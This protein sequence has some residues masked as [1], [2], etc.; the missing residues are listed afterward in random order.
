MAEISGDTANVCVVMSTRNRY[1]MLPD[2]LRSVL[3]SEYDSFEVLVVDQSTD[4]PSSEVL[5]VLS[6]P[7]VRHMPTDT[8]GLSVARNIGF[9]AARSPIVLM[10]DDDCIVSASWI[11]DVAGAIEADP[12]VACVYTDVIPGPHDSTAGFVPYTTRPHDL[13]FDRLRDYDPAIGIG[14]SVGYRRDAL[15][16]VGGFDEQLGPGARFRAADDVDMAMRLL[17]AQF[18]VR[19][20]TTTNVV[21]LGFRTNEEG[22]QLVRGYMYG[23]AAAFAKLVRTR[24]VE[25]LRPLGRMIWYSLAR[26]VIDSIKRRELPPVLGRIEYTLRGFG[27]GLRAPIDASTKRF[28]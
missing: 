28:V 12:T 4:S 23:T 5:R 6:D 8:V 19:Y 24:E 20:I 25:A 18:P 21:H 15:I 16:A 9:R 7:R 11:A 13:R 14:A 22:R 2:A 3:E 10:T 27:A 26:V 17:A 1:D